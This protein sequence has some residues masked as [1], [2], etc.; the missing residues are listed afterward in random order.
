MHQIIVPEV[1]RHV[2]FI[3]SDEDR[4]A[5][6]VTGSQPLHAV[7]IFVADDRAVNLAITDHY[8]VQHVRHKVTLVQPGDAAPSGSHCRWM[9]YQI[10][11][12]R[13]APANEVKSDGALSPIVADLI[14]SSA[15]SLNPE[16]MVDHKA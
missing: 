10:Q 15:S 9:P 4:L 8:G 14:A 5:M 2:H 16:D 13:R 1:S 7:V 11:S 12:A 6:I 3:P